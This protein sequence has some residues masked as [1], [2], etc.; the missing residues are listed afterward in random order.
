MITLAVAILAVQLIALVVVIVRDTLDPEKEALTMKTFFIGGFILFQSSS[1]IY[2]LMSG[3]YDRVIPGDLGYTGVMFGLIS[4]IFIVLTL[5]IYKRGWWVSNFAARSTTERMVSDG[6]LIAIGLVAL[7]TGVMLRDVMGK[8]P[9]LGVLT[10]MLSTGAFCTAL[11]AVGWVWARRPFNFAAITSLVLIG[12][13]TVGLILNNTF[14]RRGLVGAVLATIW[15]GYFARWR[16]GYR[17]VLVLRTVVI[18]VLGLAL[19]LL[20][21]A[22][23]G[24]KGKGG[25]LGEY[26]T[27]FATVER[28]DIT[29]AALGMVSGQF[30]AANSMWLIESV[31]DSFERWPLHSLRYFVTQPIPRIIWAGKPWSLGNEMVLNAGISGVKKDEFSLGAGIVGHL[32][33]DVTLISIP[34]YAIIIGL[35]LRYMDERVRL[36]PSNPFIVIPIGAAAAQV[37]GMPRGELGLF[38]FNAVAWVTGAVIAVHVAA[39]AVWRRV[40]PVDEFDD[41][42]DDHGDGG[43]GGEGQSADARSNAMITADSGHR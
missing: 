28:R 16:L 17:P 33:V 22:T 37:L 26:L 11:A 32:V 8:I 3:E 25:S 21:S 30:A 14:S 35:S 27:A 5:A 10:D 19:V 39:P 6:G 36:H 43:E 9:V 41:D 20:Q 2:T 18:G 24:E 7:L 38:A 12:G 23:R 15:A 40:D 4:S 1:G 29:D 31:P 42:H 13:A 34:L